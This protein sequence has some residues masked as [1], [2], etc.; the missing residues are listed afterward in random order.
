MEA[1]QR[2]HT[3]FAHTDKM[4]F[5]LVVSYAIAAMPITC[6]LS[7]TI[8]F[9]LAIKSSVGTYCAVT[10]DQQ[11]LDHPALQATLRYI[12]MEKIQLSK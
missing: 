11:Y 12:R 3:S 6:Y 7:V 4:N 10:H 9:S 8:V 1:E 2:T 5:K